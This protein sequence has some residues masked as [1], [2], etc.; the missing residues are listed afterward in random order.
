[1]GITVRIEGLDECRAAWSDGVRELGGDI[2]RGVSEACKVGK[3]QLRADAPVKSGDL[4]R[5]IRGGLTSSQ[6]LSAE[7]EV[8]A[9]APY[10]SYVEEGTEPHTILPRNASALRFEVGGKTVFAKSVNHPGTKP[11]DFVSRSEELAS[12][13]LDRELDAAISRFESEFH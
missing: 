8:V 6:A 11:N 7:G 5:S 2:R 10:A 13:T 4:R 1:M 12:I 9:E 3:R